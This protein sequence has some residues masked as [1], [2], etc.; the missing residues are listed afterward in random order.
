M[1]VTSLKQQTQTNPETLLR[2][3]WQK[4]FLSFLKDLP[5]V[6]GQKKFS[7]FWKNLQFPKMRMEWTSTASG[8]LVYFAK[9]EISWESSFRHYLSA[10]WS[11]LHEKQ[12]MFKERRYVIFPVLK[13]V[14][15]VCANVIE[16]KLKRLQ[17][18]AWTVQKFLKL[19]IMR[20]VL[21]NWSC[22]ASLVT[23]SISSHPTRVK[24]MRLR[25][26]RKVDFWW[27]CLKL[28]DERGRLICPKCHNSEIKKTSLF[29]PKRQ[30]WPLG[31]ITQILVAEALPPKFELIGTSIFIG[32]Y[33]SRTA[34]KKK[35]RSVRAKNQPTPVFYWS[36]L[37]SDPNWQQKKT[38]L[39]WR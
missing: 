22:V 27:A 17:S 30:F 37:I 2:E 8:P 38:S 6:S 12:K 39:F 11:W 35:K 5:Y 20:N 13:V 25:N 21:N 7:L 24:K 29:C 32:R 10:C 19:Y 36:R 15:R 18:H 26:N 34:D 16:T 33:T 28:E 4:C 31:K 9:L 1:N 23:C 3:F 14:H